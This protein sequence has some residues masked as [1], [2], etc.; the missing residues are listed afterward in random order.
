MPDT[1]GSKDC[2]RRERRHIT[3]IL[4]CFGENPV[5]VAVCKAELCALLHRNVECE[6]P[7]LL[8]DLEGNARRN[9]A[10]LLLKAERK[11]RRIRTEVAI[12]LDAKIALID[13]QRHISIEFLDRT[14]VHA[15]RNNLAAERV[16]TEIAGDMNLQC[17]AMEHQREHPDP[18]LSIVRDDVAMRVHRRRVN[19]GT[20]HLDALINR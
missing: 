10:V 5:R 12:P 8:L 7:A 4:C 6:L 17:L 9:G 20:E 11:E 14:A 19:E 3:C 1:G 15:R 16:P 2:L 18:H 13:L